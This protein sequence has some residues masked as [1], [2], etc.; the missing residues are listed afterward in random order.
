MRF[1]H[2]SLSWW[3]F[4][5]LALL[6]VI[7]WWT[8]G[9]FAASS[10]VSRLASGSYR[11]SMVRR[12]PLAVLGLAL[13]LVAVALMDPVLP[14]TETAIQSRGLDIVMLLDLSSSMQEQMERIRP[15]RD[16]SRL[17]FTTRDSLAARVPGKTRLEATKDAIKSFVARRRDDRIALIVFSDNAYVVSPLTFDH[18]YLLRYIDMVDDQILR[19]EGMT[20][21]GD[22]LALANYLLARQAGVLRRNQVVVLFTDGENNK[23]RDPVDVLA[24]SNAADIRVHFVGIDLEEEVRT[25][26][27]VQTLFQAVT[28]YGGRYFDANTVRD[29]DAASRTI[30]SIEKGVLVN[31]VHVRDEPVY[32]WFA[33]P[34]LALIVA[35]V[36]LRAIP[37]FV[38]QT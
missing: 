1:L 10:T 22:G 4:G 15:S 7:R 21:I 31:H 3:L 24:E 5:A 26:A 29:L 2:P 34:A 36:G 18:G 32:Q 28:R 9:R 16:M 25:K 37:F 11:A 19:G 17:T 6:P 35:A 14:S 12:L 38:D 13:G 30:D 33:L 23:G 27:Q 20:A 8:R